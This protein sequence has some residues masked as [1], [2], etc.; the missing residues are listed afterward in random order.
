M[1]QEKSSPPEAEKEEYVPFS[2]RLSRRT[3]PPPT[4]KA[5]FDTKSVDDANRKRDKRF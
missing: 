1:Q 2:Q 5:S 3:D 4:S